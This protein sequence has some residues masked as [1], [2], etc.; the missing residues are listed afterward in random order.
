MEQLLSRVRHKICALTEFGLQVLEQSQRRILS[1][2]ALGFL[3][4]HKLEKSGCVAESSTLLSCVQAVTG[5][6][7]GRAGQPESPSCFGKAAG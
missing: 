6:V 1:H 3:E 2:T 7:P 4:L 5:D